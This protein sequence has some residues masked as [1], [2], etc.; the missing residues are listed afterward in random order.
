MKK[1]E[2][3]NL[4]VMK[5]SKI[6][7]KKPEQKKNAFNS[8]IIRLIQ[9]LLQPSNV[10]AKPSPSLFYNTLCWWWWVNP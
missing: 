6:L 3:E 4:F 9:H 5:K 10:T 2:R 1:K 7:H 8:A